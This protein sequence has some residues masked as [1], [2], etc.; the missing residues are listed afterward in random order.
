MKKI[1]MLGIIALS[2]V[3]MAITGC[4][5]SG[6]CPFKAKKAALCGCGASKES[7]E[8]AKACKKPCELCKC[9]APKGSEAC[10]AACKK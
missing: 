6:S 10:A 3:A 8:C 7:A 4:C 9:G 1:T 2:A 5:C